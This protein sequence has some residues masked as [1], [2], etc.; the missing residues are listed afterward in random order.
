MIRRLLPILILFF[1]CPTNYAQNRQ[2]LPTNS[3]HGGS[4]GI[5]ISGSQ[6]NHLKMKA[7]IGNISLNDTTTKKGDF[8]ELRTE[9]AYIAGT[10]GEP[11][12]P[13]FRK[14][15]QIPMG[16]KPVVTIKHAD[17]TIYTLSDFDIK[18]KLSP[19]QPSQSKSN[20]KPKFKYKRRSYRLSGSAV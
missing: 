18:A 13:A 14:L 2:I 11:Q 5:T 15:V 20:D 6:P 10:E 12:L 7:D 8:L 16:A 9:G 3:N 19:R 4:N 17:T 1:C